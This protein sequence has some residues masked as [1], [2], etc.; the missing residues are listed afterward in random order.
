MINTGAHRVSQ[1][2][3]VD[4]IRSEI[5]D[6]KLVPGARLPTYDDLQQR[7][8]TTR[9]TVHR[10]CRRLISLGYI[11][12]TAKVGTYVSSTP[13]HLYRYAIAFPSRPDGVQYWTSYWTILR[14]A[15]KAVADA[16]PPTQILP[17][18][19]ITGHADV[20]DYQRLMADVRSQRLAG[21]IL[22]S[23]PHLILNTPLLQSCPVPRVYIGGDVWRWGIPSVSPDGNS[24]VGRALAHAAE[25]SRRRPML[26]GLD[27]SVQS[28]WETWSKACRS[29]R[30]QAARWQ[31]QY[32]PRSPW[33]AAAHLTQVL[34]QLPAQRRPDALVV[35]DDHLVEGV[36]AGLLLSKLRA[37]Q[38][39]TVIAHANFPNPPRALLPVTY[40][41]YDSR[42]LIRACVDVL[43]AQRRGEAPPRTTLVPA[44]FASELAAAA[45][46][47][48]EFV[49]S[50]KFDPSS[51]RNEL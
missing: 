39:P 48:P 10:A 33:D 22:L 46:E 15:A 4:A 19:E 16:S 1:E 37:S 43:D 27:G 40:L 50:E 18:Y 3:I 51:E 6:G 5:I 20:E 28:V 25:H 24:F 26:I 8:G 9:T 44:V 13:P 35:A 2:T 38:L 11:Q 49:T 30:I 14:A 45:M 36:T 12:S 34:M 47:H 42:Q 17:F 41:G 23:G 7:F 21:I 31:I 29:H 32:L